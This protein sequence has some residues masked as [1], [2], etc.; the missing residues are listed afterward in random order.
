MS[1]DG[2]AASVKRI[3]ESQPQ[4]SAATVS[5]EK[6]TAVVCVVPEVKV[7]NDWQKELGEK[8]ANHLTTC[9]FKS[10]LQVAASSTPIAIWKLQQCITIL[11]FSTL[12]LT[13]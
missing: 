2:C 6:E 12:S 9:G 5:F 1:C 10:G 7:A 11:K 3:L 8:L 13:N 4:V